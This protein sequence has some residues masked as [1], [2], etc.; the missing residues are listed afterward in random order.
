MSV[1]GFVIFLGGYFWAAKHALLSAGETF[2]LTDTIGPRSDS[3][4]PLIIQ[5]KRLI[6]QK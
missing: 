2:Q 4:Q 5:K 1:Q 3:A 6:I